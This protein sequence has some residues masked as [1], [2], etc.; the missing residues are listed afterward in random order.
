[1][2]DKSEMFM[3]KDSMPDDEEVPSMRDILAAVMG[4]LAGKIVN[5]KQQPSDPLP[6]EGPEK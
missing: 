2:V 1:M 3:P 5:R 6:E 4:A